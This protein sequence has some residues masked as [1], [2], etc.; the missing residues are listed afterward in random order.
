[1]IAA[2]TVHLA[3]QN[4]ISNIFVQKPLIQLQGMFSLS[5][6]RSS[7]SHSEVGWSVWQFGIRTLPVHSI[8]NL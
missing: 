5:S 6:T 1:M 2:K 4:G 3:G 8:L 7:A